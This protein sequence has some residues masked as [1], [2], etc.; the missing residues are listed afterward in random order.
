MEKRKNWLGASLGILAAAM[1]FGCSAQHAEEPQTSPLAANAVDSPAANAGKTRIIKDSKQEVE[2]PVTAKRIVDVSGSTEE[3]LVMGIEPVASGNTD[4]ANAKLFTPILAQKLKPDTINTG[5]YHGGV[6]VEAVTL[7]APDLILA[8]PTNAKMYDQLQKI[9][10]TLLV[11]YSYDAFRQRFAYVADAVGKQKEM[12][13]WLQAYDARA[14]ELH[15]Q[16]TR[17]TKD[18]TFAVIE[19]TPKIIRLYSTAGIADMLFNDMRLPKDPGTP[20]PDGWG[21]KETNLEGLSTM[22]PDH[23]ILMADNDQNVLEQSKLWGNL[24]AVKAGHVYRLT[25]V[26]NYNEAFTALGRQALMERIG[27]E[28]LQK[29]AK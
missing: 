24:K 9:A 10:P 4:K 5:W 28:I 11:P 18:E 20:A 17:I 3:L 2:I 23:I 29:A 25:S 1:L 6:N 27:S 15:D 22:N 12:K 14:S 21:G 7:A 13:E 16:I 26:Q 19:A 8:N